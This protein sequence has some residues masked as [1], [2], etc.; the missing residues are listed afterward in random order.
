MERE[1]VYKN[2]SIVIPLLPALPPSAT[3]SPVLHRTLSPVNRI[4]PIPLLS[5]TL[6]LSLLGS[7]RL[8]RYAK[9]FPSYPTSLVL[10]PVLPPVLP[11][12]LLPARSV[13]PSPVMLM[14]SLLTVPTAL[15]IHLHLSQHTQWRPP[16]L[17]FLL[18]QCQHILSHVHL[19]HSYPQ[20]P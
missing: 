17:T 13:V 4:P 9:I 8:R 7:G 19:D 2:G 18:A 16:T 1:L 5:P 10:L 20:T 3:L 12:V 6:V 15:I 14:F 11:S